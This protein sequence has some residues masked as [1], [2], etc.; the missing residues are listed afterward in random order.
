[1][2]L[3]HSQSFPHYGFER[4]FEF[5]QKVGFDGVEI[6]INENFDS[7]NPTYLKTLEK[8]YS[9]PVKAFS[10]PHKREEYFIEAFENTVKEFPK[11]HL[12]LASPQSF[13]FKYKRW[14][15]N[16]VP[17]FCKKYDLKLNR[18]NA[19]FQLFLGMI[20]ERSENSLFSLREKGSVCLDLSALWASKQ[21]I[22]RSIGFLND[23]M[24]FVYLSN[25]NRNTPY[26]PLPTG[27]L[28]LESF[29]TKLAQN[30]YQGH[31]SLKINPKE[32]HEGDDKK[33]LKIL[34]ESKEFFDT[35]FTKVAG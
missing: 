24:Q 5:A 34:T 19:P 6:G 23:K 11:T 9:I 22:M 7:Q 20:P 12:N 17:K 35:Y 10:L 3:L 30:R 31:F 15:E 14:I 33:V 29:L 16:I 18:R 26:A 27:I 28:P 2:L 25:V 4:F 21:E 13:S 8:R 1:M 32:L